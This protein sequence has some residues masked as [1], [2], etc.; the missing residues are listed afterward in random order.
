[1]HD[2]HFEWRRVTSGFPKDQ[3]QGKAYSTSSQSMN[4][5]MSLGVLPV[6]AVPT[7]KPEVEWIL[8]SKLNSEG[9]SYLWDKP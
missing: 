6:P 3:C 7:N 1:M 4:L 9:F 8:S 2:G 5:V